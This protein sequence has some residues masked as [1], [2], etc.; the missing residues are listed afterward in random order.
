MYR[1]MTLFFVVFFALLVG[2]SYYYSLTRSIPSDRP[3]YPHSSLTI[4]RADGRVFAFTTEVALTPVQQAYGLMFVQK[5]DDDQAMIFPYW[6]AQETAFW[7]KNT[8]IPLDMLFVKSDRTIGH[9]VTNA[10]PQD[11][12]PIP[13][14]GPVIAVIEIKG[15]ETQKDGFAE[16]DKVDAPDLMR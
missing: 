16:G 14:Q 1:K 7:M 2:A 9:I 12:T 15:G 13:S 3:H 10:Q 11:L 6:P 5:M 4:T 8:L